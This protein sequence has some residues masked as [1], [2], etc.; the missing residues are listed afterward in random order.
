VHVEANT[1]ARILLAGLLLKLGVFGFMRFLEVLK[2]LEN[3]VLILVGFVGV[4][5]A[6]YQRLTQRD[7]KAQVAFGSIAHIRQVFIYRF[8]FSSLAK[9]SIILVLI[10]HGFIRALVFFLVREMF[11][12][13]RTRL[14]FFLNGLFLVSLVFGLF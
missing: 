7:I 9:S 12:Y 2:L 5:V 8:F 6:T 10:N 11:Y 3:R 14:I 1:L 4:M 13:Q